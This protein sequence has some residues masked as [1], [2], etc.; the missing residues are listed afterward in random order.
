MKTFNLKTIQLLLLGVYLFVCN[1]GKADNPSSSISL[2]S[3]T[4]NT[5]TSLFTGHLSYAIPIYTIEDPDFHLDIALRYSTEGFKPFH[6]SGCY[7]LDWNLVAGGCISRIVQGF[8]DEQKIEYS[9]YE[10]QVGMLQAIQDGENPVKESVFDFTTPLY[11]PKCGIQYY[12]GD[13]VYETS[14]PA[15]SHCEWDRD[16]QSDIFN[17]S[18]CGHKGRF[19][20]NNFGEPVIISGDFVDIDVSNFKVIKTNT[21]YNNSFYTPS[22][23]SSI[24]IRTTDGYTFI[25]G[26]FPNAM[27]YLT[28]VARNSDYDQYIPAISV[29]HLTKIIAPNKRVL[30]FTYSNGF[31]QS[32]NLNSLKSF[33]TDYDWSE[34][35]INEDSAHIV[36]ALHKEC[37]LQSITSSDDIPL[38]IKFRSSEESFPMYDHNDFTYSK[39]HSQLD[40]IIVLYGGDTLRTAKLTYQYKSHNPLDGVLFDYHWRYLHHVTISG[41]GTYS[42][43]YN[44]INIS[45]GQPL[46]TMYNYPALYPK[47]DAEY[48]AKV[49][50][51]GFWK[52]SSLQGLLHEVALPT[53]GKLR[54]TFGNHQYGEERRFRV[55]GT[56]DVELYSRQNADQTIGGARIEKIETFSDDTTLVETKIYSYHK[57]GSTNSSGIFYNIYE[58]FYPSDSI[59]GNP[60]VNPYNYGL[61]D[62]H[63][64]YSYVEQQ[65]S[66]GSQSYKT[67]YIY[68]TGKRGYSSVGSSFINR[69]DTMFG[70]NDTTEVCSGSLTFPAE[71]TL[72]GKLMAI[73]QYKLGLPIKSTYFQY[74]GIRNTLQG[75]LPN[76][77]DTLG[78]IDT[79]VILSKY[80]GHIARKLLVFPDVLEKTVTYEYE[81]N[82]DPMVVEKNY[83][84]DNKLRV[85]QEVTKDSKNR[86]LFT[87]YTYPDN[88]PAQFPDPLRQL[89]I[90]N[91]IG[92]P[93]ETIHGYADGDTEYI[94]GGTID[95]YSNNSYILNGGHH[96]VPYLS[97]TLVLS[98]LEPI[99]DYQPISVSNGHE[100]T[101][102]SRYTLASE[103]Y[104]DLNN[105]LQSFKTLGKPTET[106]TWNGIYPAIK[107]IGNQT[108]TYT[109]NP[110]VGVRSVTDPRGITTYYSYD[111]HG[112]LIEVY[113]LVNGQKQILSVYQYHSK[114]E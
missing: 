110:Y 86:R 55:V 32:N 108:Y 87:R 18:F 114:T 38:T 33:I 68:D 15:K 12:Q 7:G 96:Y 111:G 61:I 16:Y 106:Y 13:Y 63:I 22:D 54:F 62:S 67:A 30:N 100:I 69:N 58:I 95:L 43:N 21:Y 44:N 74:N 109:Y 66:T 73:K 77:E 98:L 42:M 24:T 53:G 8:P 82:G 103:Y 10:Q 25:F 72:T 39:P 88:L 90:F 83:S 56:K 50:R 9:T 1:A 20:I 3:Y 35:S 70:Y 14:C 101:Y 80:S 34:Q 64:G 28:T 65:T 59:L 91:R 79:I 6:P 81:G 36:Y 19:I 57:Q 85:W 31:S 51:Y 71:L 48:K 4:N 102:D 49:D 113:R 84:H 45:E 2:P 60:I 97:G 94:T 29:W 112:R 46:I 78:C 107:T 37:L 105:R 11:K 52:L 92:R 40:S 99:T 75:F 93:I 76:Q 41:I 89:V 104:F 47:T 17:F 26:E 23:S 5:N 27:E